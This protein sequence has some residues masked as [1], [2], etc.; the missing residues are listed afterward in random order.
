[1]KIEGNTLT[2]YDGLGSTGN[3]LDSSEYEFVKE[4]ENKSGHG[5][6]WYEFKA[7]KEGAMYPIVL[8]MEHM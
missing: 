4:N 6:V 2:F 8:L 3:V 1:M 7:K 5:G